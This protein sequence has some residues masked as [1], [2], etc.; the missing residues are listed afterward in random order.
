MTTVSQRLEQSLRSAIKKN[1][2]LPVKVADGILVGSVKIVSEGHLKHLHR[3][4]DLLYNS[5]FLNAVAIKIA[6][7][8]ALQSASLH[9]DQLYQLDQEYGKHF[10]D[11]QMLRAQHQKSLNNKDYDRADI[12]WARYCESRDR[13][14]T[15]K[16]KAQ[17]LSNL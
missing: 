14:E 16:N 9:A 7:I 1:P 6:N 2:I 4:G 13:A 8:M 10:V 12:I 11:S 5:V 17:S 3:D 15:A